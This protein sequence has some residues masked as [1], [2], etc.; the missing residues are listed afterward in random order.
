MNRI[1]LTLWL[2]AAIFSAFSCSGKEEFPREQEIEK[3]A[4]GDSVKI[5]AYD[6]AWC[7]FSD[8]RAIYYSDHEIV[9]GW[10]KKDGSV[11]V[12]C[13]DISVESL[14]LNTIYADM[15]VDDHNN[16]AFARLPDGNVFAMYAWHGGR[17]GVISNTTA[18]GADVFS[19][20][21]NVI[22]KPKSLELLQDF[23]KETYTYANPW[24]LEGEENRLFAFGR[25]IGYKPN[26]IISGDNGKTWR[27]QYVVV[28]R[29]PFDPGNRP[30][31]K[32][33]SDG[34]TK[35]H[36]VFTDGHPNVEPFNSV[37]YCYYEAGA[38]WKA[39]GEKICDLE[40]LPFEPG[41]ASLVYQPSLET[42]RAWV[43]DIA[44]NESKEPVVLYSRHPQTTDIR[45]HY[46]WYNAE[47]GKWE[48]AEMC[49]AGKWFPQTPPSKKERET[50]Y[51]GNLTLHPLQPH[52]VFVSRPVEGKFE[53][54]KFVTHDQGNSWEITPITSNSVYDNVRP[55]IPR[56]MPRDAPAIVLWMENKRY[57]HYT[58]Y[59][60]NIRYF[61]D[62]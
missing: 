31:A 18:G 56:N 5:L 29:E 61:I 13:F 58:D 51:L 38:F 52:I 11:E 24:V 54:Q 41:D 25:W 23:P 46:A 27:E 17:R 48:D 36:M 6:G 2:Y 32:Y 40:E 3:P 26:M 22:F 62:R 55:Y 44:Q 19:F 9:T 42:G 10:V 15:Q 53:I 50:Y 16:P 47:T 20:R 8:P 34:N 60:T 43:A 57:I 14:Q 45:Y 35:I 59:D 7:W 12:A 1:L 33:H 21:G 49:K 4:A 28:S 39:G 30:Y 37:Y